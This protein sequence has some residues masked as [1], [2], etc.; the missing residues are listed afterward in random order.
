MGRIPV[1]PDLSLRGHPN[2]FVIGDLALCLDEKGRQVP[3]VAPA[4]MQEGDY[5][6]RWIVSKLEG[7]A[8]PPFRY[9]DKGNLATIGRGAA[10]AEIGRFRF[11]GFL[12]WIVWLF[13]HILHL[14]GFEN[15]ILVL[16]QWAW[17]YIT[18]NRSAR[19][20]TGN[21]PVELPPPGRPS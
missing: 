16:T 20:I 13:V 3:G 21:P 19:L 7:K 2:V 1:E 15:R 17:N 9:R 4:A 11:S 6:A 12:A 10:V 14:V 18:W 5:V 8:E